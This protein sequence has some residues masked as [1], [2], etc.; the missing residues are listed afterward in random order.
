MSLPV[1]DHESTDD[2]SMMRRP[3][4]PHLVHGLQGSRWRWPPSGSQRLTP[5]P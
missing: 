4:Q 5:T 1:R 2:A 3:S